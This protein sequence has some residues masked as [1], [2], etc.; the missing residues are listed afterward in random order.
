[1]S[2]W[3]NWTISPK[4]ANGPI[5]DS[6]WDNSDWGAPMRDSRD[7]LVIWWHHA[8]FGIW[9]CLFSDVKSIADPGENAW[10]V[11]KPKYLG[12]SDQLI[13][14]LFNLLFKTF[15]G[16]WNTTATFSPLRHRFLQSRAQTGGGERKR[17]KLPWAVQFVN[18]SPFLSLGIYMC[19][20]HQQRSSHPLPYLADSHSGRPPPRSFPIRWDEVDAPPRSST[21]P[22]WLLFL[23]F[24]HVAH[25]L[26]TRPYAPH[27]QQLYLLPWPL[28]HCLAPSWPLTK[29][30]VNTAEQ[31]NE[32]INESIRSASY[33]LNPLQNKAR[34]AGIADPFLWHTWLSREFQFLFSKVGEK[35]T[36]VDSHLCLALFQKGFANIN[37]FLKLRCIEVWFT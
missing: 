11:W 30:S 2:I 32:Q 16:P 28:P 10:K 26:T 23:H 20:F 31:G 27:E 37:H 14:K 25:S 5:L 29:C 1:M 15:S 9:I 7:G 24:Y 13:W 6:S 22:V 4:W 3:I 36:K 18:V 34:F 21:V 35:F 17:G 12:T 19:A 33:G 8:L